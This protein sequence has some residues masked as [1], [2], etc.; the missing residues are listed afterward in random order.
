M[1]NRN[2]SYPDKNGANSKVGGSTFKRRKD[3][4]YANAKSA[5]HCKE[6]EVIDSDAVIRQLY[7]EVAELEVQPIERR[8]ADDRNCNKFDV[9][10]ETNF[11][12]VASKLIEAIVEISEKKAFFL[13]F[14][15]IWVKLQVVASTRHCITALVEDHSSVWV[16]TVVYANPRVTTKR[17]LWKYLDSI[18]KCFALPWL[19]VGEFN[20]ITNTCDKRGGRLGFSNCGFTDWIDRNNLFDLGFTSPKFTW[21]TKIGIREEIWEKLDRA[22]CSMDWRLRY[23]EGYVRHL[24]RVLSD[25]CHVLI[26]LYSNHIPNSKCLTDTINEQEVKQSIYNI[27]RFKA[28]R[29][30]GFPAVVF[31]KF[32]NHYKYDMINMVAECFMKG[33]VPALHKFK[34]AKG[35]V[36]FIAWKIDLAKACDKLQYGFIKQAL[37]EVGIVGR[38]NNLIMSRVSSVQYKV[39]L[40]GEL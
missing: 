1:G 11:V 12:V 24:P 35:K 26:Q 31:Q 3:G 13:S 36:G 15:M 30:D 33:C 28:P 27:S 38:L 9:Q 39:I 21:M 18:R 20:E 7:K 23:A 14:S 8:M 37:E 4:E 22:L 17:L 16:L 19:I 40:N 32:W 5:S 10:N 29:P 25:H 2:T 34:N 6:S